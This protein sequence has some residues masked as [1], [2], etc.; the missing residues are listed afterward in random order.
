MTVEL[1]DN[2]RAVTGESPL[3]DDTR[4][5][6][7]WIDIQGRRLLGL[8]GDGCA[9]Q[10][11]PLESE[12]GLIAL[13]EDGELV[14]GL[15][16]GLYRLNPET[17]TCRI[18]TPITSPHPNVRLNDGK[19]DVQGRLWF[20]SMDKSGSGTP[21]GALYCR[22]P[23]GRIICVRESVRIPNAIA[24]S[25]DGGTL[26]FSDS[27]SQ[28]VL[29]FDLD[30]ATGTL[31]GEHVL[32]RFDGNDK[33]DGAIVDA[34]GDL[35]VAV[36]HGARVDRIAASG[37]RKESFAMPVTKPTMAA[38]GGKDLSDLFITSQSRFLSGDDLSRFPLAGRLLV[39]KGVGKG[40]RANRVCY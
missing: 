4:N 11:F 9:L 24:V 34:A 37:D 29:A 22:H 3:W 33:P 8:R 14:I 40:L 26:Y 18:L 25:P 28:A 30:P 32:C 17:G 5:I 12:P 10:P 31:S 19:P 23:G 36:V 2:E 27:P 15:E 1:A 38:F 16:D 13:G 21:V 20:G 39:N 6:L 7:W 35:W